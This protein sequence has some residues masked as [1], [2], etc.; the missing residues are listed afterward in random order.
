MIRHLLNDILFGLRLV[1]KIPG[2]SIIIVLIL[3]LGI[4]AT[5]AIFSI[6]D[7]VMLRPLPYREPEA[8][9]S[10]SCTLILGLQSTPLAVG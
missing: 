2:F 9:I 7:A 4:G 10:T 6:L 8:Y 3:T 5:T 1:R